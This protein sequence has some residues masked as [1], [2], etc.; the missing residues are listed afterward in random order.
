MIILNSVG[1]C[2]GR[3]WFCW[4]C[5][6]QGC[7]IQR[8]R[9]YKPK[10]VNDQM[11]CIGRYNTHLRLLFILSGSILKVKDSMFSLLHLIWI[12]I[13]LLSQ[14]WTPYIPRLM[15]GPS[16]MDARQ[17]SIQMSACTIVSHLIARPIIMQEMFSMQTGMRSWW[18][19]LLLF[20]LLE[21][22]VV[23]NR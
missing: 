18:G 2:L 16:H 1:C 12:V 17:A 11:M 10:Q 3:Q 7:S 9:G 6:L 20:L 5:N 19:Q 22:L 14:V 15:G 23:R 8:H 13:W 4:F 21:V